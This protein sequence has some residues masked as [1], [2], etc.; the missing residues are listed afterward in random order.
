MTTPSVVSSGADLLASIPAGIF[1]SPAPASNTTPASV[2]PDAAQD[3]PAPDGDAIETIASPAP[4][5]E[6]SP[7]DGETESTEEETAPLEGETETPPAETQTDNAEDLPEG[8]I[9]G[10]DR[11]G[12]EGLFVTPA[13]WA[14][15]YGDHQLVQK[16]SEVLGEPVTPEALQVRNDAYIAQERLFNDVTSGE[17][18]AQSSVIGYM[19]DEMAR[20][21]EE[22]AVGADPSVP[23]ATSFYNTIKERAP[24]AYAGLRFQAAKDL[25]G[26]MFREASEKGDEALFLSAAHFSRALSGF[27]HDVQDV[28]QIRSAAE[29]A[30]LPFYTKAEMQ[31]MARGADPMAQLRAENTRLQSQLN[32]RTTNNQAAQ[33]DQWFSGTKTAVNTAIANDAITPALA[34]VAEAWKAFPSDYQRLVVDP[35]HREVTAALKSNRGFNEEIEML[36]AQARRATSAQRRDQIGEQIQQRYVNRAKLAADAKKGEI[37]K[38]AAKFLSEQSQSTHARRLAAQDR[39]APRG[40]SST[41]PRS[42]VPPAQSKM[43]ARFDAS[44]AAQELN[45]LLG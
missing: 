5:E 11:N 25:L 23:F 18:T 7:A 38:F 19:L 22:G 32:G 3:S 41:V 16:T 36:H 34:S 15:I 1:D 33:F 42:L 17:P 43:G 45:T 20:A 12:K 4:L 8:V 28:A 40:A 6:T 2:A 30:G 37:L 39:T 21:K 29:R 35:L 44:L 14:T 10:K 13:R 31:G 26:E 24:E 9:K 27:G